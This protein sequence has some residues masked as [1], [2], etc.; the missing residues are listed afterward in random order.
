MNE[1]EKSETDNIAIVELLRKK[2][3]AGGEVDAN[4]VVALAVF[5]AA[6]SLL[7]RWPMH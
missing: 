4:V 3:A 5:E 7:R 1:I 6:P 2:I